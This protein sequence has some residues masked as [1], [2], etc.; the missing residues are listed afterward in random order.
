[1]ESQATNRLVIRIKLPPQAPA[2]P[3]ARPPLSK[4]AL[5]LVLVPVAIAL[6]WWGISMFR[7]EPDS[8]AQ[9]ARRPATGGERSRTCREQRAAAEACCR[10]ARCAAFT[11]QRS[12]SR[13]VARRS[14][15][16]PRHDQGDDSGDSRQERRRS[17][18]GRGRIRP[19]PLFRAAR[20]GSSQEMDVHASEIGRGANDAGEVLLQALWGNS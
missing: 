16:R 4:L 15:H 1:M 3:P 9:S 2:P 11:H 18:R 12:A 7:S 20:S 10:S 13:R 6:G 17:H 14:E 19:E 8:Q 5:S